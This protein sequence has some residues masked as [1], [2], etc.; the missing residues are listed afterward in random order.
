MPR[1]PKVEKHTITVVI[2]GAPIDVVLHPPTGSR[3]SWY[4]YW[5]G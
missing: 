5:A 4:A 1:K 2:N 3:M